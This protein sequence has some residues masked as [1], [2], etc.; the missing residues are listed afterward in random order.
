MVRWP[1]WRTRPTSDWPISRRDVLYLD[2][3]PPMNHARTPRDEGKSKPQADTLLLSDMAPSKRSRYSD[4]RSANASCRIELCGS[5]EDSKSHCHFVT[6]R[7]KRKISSRYDD[8][9]ER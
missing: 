3:H 4:G 8:E 6:P 1:K 5:F 2:S 7:G 9:I